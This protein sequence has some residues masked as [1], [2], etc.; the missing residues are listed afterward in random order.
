MYKK[1]FTLLSL[2]LLTSFF[3]ATQAQKTATYAGLAYGGFIADTNWYE[4]TSVDLLSAHINAPYGVA[5]DTNGVVM[6]ADYYNNKI[7]LSSGG[8]L[9]NRSGKLGPADQSSG[10]A[11][12][13]ASSGKLYNP[14]G[15]AIDP[16]TNTLIIADE[17][18][19]AIRRL[20]AFH[21]V[22]NT[23]QL[24]TVAG[25][26]TYINLI[27]GYGV[28]GSNDG[29]GSGAKFKGP[30]D[31]AV[32]DNG[33]IYVADRLNHTIRKITPGGVVTTVAGSAG[34]DGFADGNGSA[35]RF[36][37]PTGI[38]LENNNSCW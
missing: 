31:V 30:A 1:R 22:S 29:T 10:Y 7:R 13:S 6:L 35:A 14:A 36:F 28:S 18:N 27:N 25:D 33:N 34:N 20:S 15:I 32:D 37:L 24:T 8:Q 4:N 5:V 19:H 21:N 12:G 26:Q 38:C 16:V 23:Q 2:L 17:G 11:D 3:T 9:W